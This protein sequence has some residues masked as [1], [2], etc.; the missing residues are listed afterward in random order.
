[1]GIEVIHHLGIAL[2]VPCQSVSIRRGSST[3]VVRRFAAGISASAAELSPIF[4]DRLRVRRRRL[5]A[6]G[7]FSAW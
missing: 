6:G 2:P 4:G 3:V 7:S 1:V 5:R